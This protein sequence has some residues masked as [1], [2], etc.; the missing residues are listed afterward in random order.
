L[1]F[2]VLTD[3][4]EIHITRFQPGDRQVIDLGVPRPLRSDGTAG[5]DDAAHRHLY[6]RGD[7]YRLDYIQG[8]AVGPD[9]T[10]FLMDIY[11]QLNVAI[12]PQLTKN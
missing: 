3:A 9:G 4:S 2:P 1:Y 5:L 8:A 7:R 12:F 10:L 11:P 6:V